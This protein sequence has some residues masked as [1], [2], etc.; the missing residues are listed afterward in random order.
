MGTSVL[1]CF[2]LLNGLKNAVLVS[3]LL[4]IVV[5]PRYANRAK[6]IKNKPKINEDPKDA[7]LRQYQE[8][9]TQLKAMLQ[10]NPLPMPQPAKSKISTQ[11]VA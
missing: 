10:G 7:L 11:I 9:I 4:R 3:D 5:T 8:E 2:C 1:I 6:N